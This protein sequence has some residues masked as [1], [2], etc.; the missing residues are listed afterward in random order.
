MEYAIEAIK[1]PSAL[2]AAPLRCSGPFRSGSAQKE[3]GRVLC[4]GFA[5]QRSRV[6]PASQGDATL[7]RTRRTLLL[8]Q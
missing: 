4:F 5:L 2:L 6:W 7:S 8:S 1:V 3:A